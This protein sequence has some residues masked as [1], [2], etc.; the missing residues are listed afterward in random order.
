MCRVIFPISYQLIDVM[1]I[2]LQAWLTI[3]ILLYLILR[4]TWRRSHLSSVVRWVSFDGY[5]CCRN[6][7][8]IKEVKT[9]ELKPQNA[10]NKGRRIHVRTL[11]KRG[12]LENP[13]FGAPIKYPEEVQARSNG[14]RSSSILAAIFEVLTQLQASAFGTHSSGHLHGFSTSFYS[15]ALRTFV[16]L[17]LHARRTCARFTCC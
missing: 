10:T 15:V 3:L 7:I 12:F 1:T 16:L 2:S 13:T 14:I 17:L 6:N 8:T 9:C 4:H 5:G 11:I